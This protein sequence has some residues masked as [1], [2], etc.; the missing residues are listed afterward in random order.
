V[1]G[2]F[3]FR[4]ALLYEGGGVEDFGCGWMDGWMD[5]WRRG[6]LKGVGSVGGEG[7]EIWDRDWEVLDR[8]RI[9]GI[10]AD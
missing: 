2:R 1:K 9:G 10:G 8:I 7:L 5:G 6:W 4:C 3:R